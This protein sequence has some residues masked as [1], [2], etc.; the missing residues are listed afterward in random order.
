[1]KFGLGEN[2]AGQLGNGT[3]TSQNVPVVVLVLANTVV[4][5][6]AGNEHSLA[7]TSQGH[8][9]SWGSNFFGQL[10]NAGN[11]INRNI[12]EEIPALDNGVSV[13]AGGAH[14]LVSLA[15]GSMRSWGFNL[16]G[17]LG[18]G[19]ATDQRIP[20][21]VSTNLTVQT[22][23]TGNGHALALKSDG[24]VFSWGANFDGQLGLGDTVNRLIPTRVGAQFDVTDVSSSSF[25]TIALRANGSVVGWGNNSSGNSGCLSSPRVPFPFR[26]S[27]QASATPLRSLRAAASPWR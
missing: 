6:S 19:E 25:H 27:F 3:N 9:M 26:N 4:K 24:T 12:P 1:M 14:S 5:I 21:A 16:F 8:V 2:S 18:N 7:L 22:V 10:G 23:S 17:Q 11:A 20:V 13:S 15:D